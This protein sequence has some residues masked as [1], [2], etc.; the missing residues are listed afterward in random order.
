MQNG[1]RPS[2]NALQ[3]FWKLCFQTA[4]IQNIVFLTKEAHFYLNQLFQF[5][6]YTAAG[7]EENHMVAF[8]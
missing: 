6:Q 7:N 2:E 3:F 1:V 8:L 5:A 4:Y